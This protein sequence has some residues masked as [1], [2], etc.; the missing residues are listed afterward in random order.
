LLFVEST[1]SKNR[2]TWDYAT[3]FFVAPNL[4]L[5]AG[6]AAVDLPD[7]VKTERHLFLPGTPRLNIDEVSSRKPYAIRCDV[8]E[9]LYKVNGP[10]SK[11]IAIL[12]SG[13]FETRDFLQLSSDPVAADATIDIIGYPGEKRSNWLRE[14]HPELKS[15]VEGANAGELLL[16][17]RQ[18]VI[19]RGVVAHTGY[20]DMTSYNISTCPGLSGSCL[21]HQ[22][23]VHGI[24]ALNSALTL[25]VHVGDIQFE[26]KDPAGLRSAVSFR[27]EETKK[28]LRRHKLLP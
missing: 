26:E 18:L 17:T 28:L 7:A 3:A 25:G 23:K 24:P 15:L 16:P 1:D 6:H 21:M 12:S 19:T 4:L 9:T 14:K 10:I 20:A 5:T 27:S 22:G 13:N 8:V 2:T 11:D